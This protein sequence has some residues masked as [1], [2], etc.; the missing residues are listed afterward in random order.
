MTKNP[1]VSIII[2]TYNYEKYIRYAIESAMMQNYPNSEI[3][4][5]DDG[6]TDNTEGVISSYLDKITY[7]KKE[8][9]GVASAR[10]VG[11]KA[12]KGKYISFLDADDLWI[13]DKIQLQVNYMEHNKHIMVCSGDTASFNEK[14]VFQKSMKKDLKV[15]E[16]K[17]FDKLLIQNFVI[18]ITTMIRKEVLEEVGLYDEELKIA[19]DYNLYLRIAMKNHSF[20]FIDKVLAKRRCH[21]TNI[22]SK[23]DR[24]YKYNLLNLKK[25][26]L[27]DPSIMNTYHWKKAIIEL[28]FKYG[29]AYFFLKDFQSAKKELVHA[30]KMPSPKIKAMAL[31]F[32]CYF[33]FH[34]KLK[35]MLNYQKFTLLLNK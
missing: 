28:H 34:T 23:V 14:E 25:I 12:S 18:N 26:A 32:L 24:N 11:V 21:E 4:V 3:I 33:P 6:S 30:I 7:I 17:I 22:T 13:H 20:G 9:G 1:L 15:Y 35:K 19:E 31:L 16:G 8:N 5:V 10:N 29:L 27:I 2:V